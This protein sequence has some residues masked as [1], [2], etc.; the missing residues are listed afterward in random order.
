MNRRRRQTAAPGRIRAL[1]RQLV[2]LLVVAVASVALWQAWHGLD[3]PLSV[4]RVTGELTESERDRATELVS[5]YLPAGIL[6]FDAAGLRDRLTRESWV[7]A[8]SIRRQWP[9][10][11]EVHLVPEVPVARWRD[12]ALLSSRGRVIEPLELVGMDALPRLRG[13][14]G[15]APQVM[16]VFQLV[17]EALRPFGLEVEDLQEDAAGNVRVQTRSGMEILLGGGDRAS[18]LQ[19]VATVI[20]RG[21]KDRLPDVARLDARYDNGIAVAWRD[22]STDSGSVAQIDSQPIRGSRD[23]W[24]LPH[25][26]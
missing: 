9:D 2:R 8:A 24:P 17:S 20:E 13:P 10:T 3:R 26:R 5:S 25:H 18:R 19:R 4:V 23:A 21:L 11:V 22:L 7:D 16:E 12:D 15:T 1:G 14:V 6:G